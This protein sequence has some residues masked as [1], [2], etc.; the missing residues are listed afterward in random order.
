MRFTSDTNTEND[1]GR[2][3][4][5]N[6]KEDT[7]VESAQSNLVYNSAANPSSESNEPTASG[8]NNPT[9]N[10]DEQ[11]V[12]KSPFNEIES[13]TITTTIDAL[14]DLVN[15]KGKI[16]VNVAA[17]Q[18]KVSPRIIESWS[19]ALESG[20]LIKITYAL[21]HMYIEPTNATPSTSDS[22][23]KAV[24]MDILEEDIEATTAEISHYFSEIEKTSETLNK[25]EQSYK[26]NAPIIYSDL[27]KINKV[28][29]VIRNESKKVEDLEHIV[30]NSYEDFK[31]KY[32][33]ISMLVANLSRLSVENMAK[34]KSMKI[35]DISNSIESIESDLNEITKMKNDGINRIRSNLEYEFKNLE[36][37]T[38]KRASDLSRKI[39]SM[40][41]ELE[42]VRNSLKEELKEVSHS[43]EELKKFTKEIEISKQDLEKHLNNFH[44]ES[45]AARSKM[46]ASLQ[47]FKAESDNLQDKLDKLKQEFGEISLIDSNLYNSKTEIKEIKAE[48]DADFAEV[49]A[50]NTALQKAKKLAAYA[51]KPTKGKVSAK[52]APNLEEVFKNINNVKSKVNATNTK[53][54]ATKNK[55]NKEMLKNIKDKASSTNSAAKKSEKAN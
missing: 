47:E 15:S 20:G 37:D 39:E 44:D 55:I 32:E 43:V 5:V 45:E 49:K 33:S 4:E 17:A 8:S 19:K 10:F 14:L 12:S 38:N 7:K 1:A 11:S 31:K 51:S 26:K 13:K 22:A 41:S 28:Y 54:S 18:L 36:Q 53:L 29:D 3:A 35:E 27:A 52:A 50:L 23:A 48:L 6:L 21:D 40:R 25:I 16:D 24:Q 30:N 2:S 34:A 42:Q 46:E 9:A